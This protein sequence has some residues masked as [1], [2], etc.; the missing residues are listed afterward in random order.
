MRDDRE[1]LERLR[2]EQANL[3]ASAAKSGSLPPDRLISRIANLELTIAALE[4]K[5]QSAARQRQ[6]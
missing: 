1:L 2:E 5:I 3:V 6:S 4:F